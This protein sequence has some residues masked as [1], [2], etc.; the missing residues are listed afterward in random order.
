[1]LKHRPA[2]R[3][4]SKLDV[5]LSKPKQHCVPP[6]ALGVC[7]VKFSMR[8]VRDAISGT[9]FARVLR[10]TGC[11]LKRGIPFA[12]FAKACGETVCPP[13]HIKIEIDDRR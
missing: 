13:F 12:S 1:M 6:L 9:I 11:F 5:H 7:N 10:S 8:L 4:T 2:I 3:N